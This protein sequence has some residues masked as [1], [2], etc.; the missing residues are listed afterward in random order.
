MPVSFLFKYV[1][2]GK[3]Y[4]GLLY[5]AEFIVDCGAKHLHRRRQAHVGV[6]KRRYIVTVVAYSL[7]E[8]LIV[9]LESCACEELVHVFTIH[10]GLKLPERL[11][12]TFRVGEMLVKEI[13][14]HV[15]AL[16]VV[17]W[18]H[19]HFSKQI[20]YRGIYDRQGSETVPKIVKG[21]ESF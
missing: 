19:G 6:Y 4:T 18:I 2:Y 11:D 16:W 15:A 9:I 1:G 13:K 8:Y 7:V 14:Y 17:A 20:L 10:V 5:I 12:Q 3:E 21:V